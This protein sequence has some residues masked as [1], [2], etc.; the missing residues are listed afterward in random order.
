MEIKLQMMVLGELGK[1]APMVLN[2]VN[3]QLD[4]LASQLGVNFKRLSRA[5][6]AHQ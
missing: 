1:G 4:N 5:V 2:I 6:G 3:S